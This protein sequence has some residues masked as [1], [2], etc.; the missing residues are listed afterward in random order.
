MDA[1]YDA[2]Y[3]ERDLRQAIVSHGRDCLVRIK[4]NRPEAPAA[5]AAGF[6]GEKPAEP[7]AETIEKSGSD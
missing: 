5:L 7:Q 2:L 6:E 3:A 4:G 1:L